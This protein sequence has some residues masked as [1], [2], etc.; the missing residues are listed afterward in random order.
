MVYTG[1]SFGRAAGRRFILDTG[2]VDDDSDEYYSGQEDDDDYEDADS[3][4]SVGGAGIRSPPLLK[5]SRVVRSNRLGVLQGQT[6]RPRSSHFYGGGTHSQRFFEGLVGD[7]HEV[8]EEEREGVVDVKAAIRLR[9]EVKA[10]RRAIA[11]G[12]RK[13]G[14]VEVGVREV[15]SGDVVGGEVDEEEGNTADVE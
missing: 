4:F 13:K 9:K 3:L 15:G 10:R 14:G 6:A 2:A 1:D 7:A 5:P 12:V 11:G 8:I